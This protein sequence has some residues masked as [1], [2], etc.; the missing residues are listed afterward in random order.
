MEF[1]IGRSLPHGQSH[2]ARLATFIS[3]F[4][5]TL[6]MFH[7]FCFIPIAVYLEYSIY[8]PEYV[9][10]I[11]SYFPS[12]NLHTPLGSPE[13]QGGHPE[14]VEGRGTR[15]RTLVN[16]QSNGSGSMLRRLN[17]HN[18]CHRRFLYQC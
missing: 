10:N 14:V 6:C 15:H 5:H 2:M 9:P 1:G 8:R 4:V 17:G 7:F 12:L 13:H 18:E 11:L 16:I 3:Q